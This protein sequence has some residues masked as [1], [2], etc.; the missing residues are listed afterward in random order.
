VTDSPAASTSDLVVVSPSP[1]N[2][3]TRLEAVVGP[4]TPSGRHY[5]RNH[6]AVP[7]HDGMLHVDGTVAHPLDI[8]VIDL[9]DRA[10]TTRTVTLEC[11]GNGR[12]TL[13]PPVPGEQWNL[14]AV[15]TAEWGGILLA[16][17]LAEAEP[18][19]ETVEFVFRGAD[20][21]FVGAAGREMA[22]ERS[23]PPS[24]LADA[25]LVTTM[26]GTPLPANHG[27]PIRLLVPGRYG[28]TSVKWLSR[29]TAV[30][31]PFRGFFQADRYVIDG[32]PL[33]PIAPRA[34]ISEPADGAVLAAGRAAEIRGYAWSGAA[35][36]VRVDVS[37]DGGGSWREATL[38]IDVG[39]VAWRPWSVSWAAPAAGDYDL[40]AV[41]TDASGG[42]QPLEQVWNTL[43]YMN[44]QA[45]PVTVRVE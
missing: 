11:A 4:I 44:N 23:L 17:I 33:G 19:P 10:T 45:Q 26:N 41:A 42:K 7:A 21:G 32:R 35:P 9:L 31:E 3:E 34:V 27:A 14:G 16:A 15:G 5:V 43:G 6:F 2:A 40:V 22:F 30:A 20:G 25:L 38:G 37:T 12:R 13:H 28:M 8:P 29:I 39:P 24:E 18:L 1:F 36:I